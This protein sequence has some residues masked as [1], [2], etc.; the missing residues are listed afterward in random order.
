MTSSTSSPITDLL[1]AIQ[2][3]FDGHTWTKSYSKHGGFE[4]KVNIFAGTIIY[5]PEIRL[6][7]RTTSNLSL[8]ENLVVLECVN[9]LLEKGYKPDSLILEN[10][11]TLGRSNKGG[12]ADITVEGPDSRI[13]LIIECKTWGKE[14]EKEKTNMQLRG[15]QLFSYLRQDRNCQYLCLYASK[16]ESGVIFYENSIVKAKD[17]ETL[18]DQYNKGDTDIKLFSNAKNESELYQAWKESYACYF[19][20]NGIFDDDAAAYNIDLKPLKIKDLKHLNSGDS[21][22]IYN[23]FAEIL[24]HN[25]IS[26]RENAF[27]K[28]ISL[29]LCKMVDENKDMEDVA[30]FQWVEGRDSYEDLQDRL[31]S[32]YRTGMRDY[33]KEEVVYFEN[34]FVDLAFRHNAKSVAKDKMLQMLKELKF[35][36]NNEF[37]FKEVHNKRLF[38]QNAKVLNE[39]VQLL[40][41]YRFKYSSAEPFLG[42]LFE[43][44]LN[45]GVKQSEGQFFTP[46]PIAQFIMNCL[47]LPEIVES[48]SREIS[49]FPKLIDYACGSG[50][51]L[52]QAIE[53]IQNII[54][55]NES[56]DSV[57][58]SWT[59]DSI[60]GV[61]RD[62]R[63]ARIAKIACFM[64]GAG[65]ANIIYGDGLDSH[66]E[67]GK[68]ES[69]DILV[70]NP[71]YSIK[72]F[73]QHLNLKNNQ[74][75]NLAYLTENSSEIEVLFIER[76]GQ[77]IKPGG[78]AA[79]ILPSSI[80]SNS[81]AYVNARKYI[82]RNFDIKGIVELGSGTFIATGTTT[83]VLFLRKYIESDYKHFLYRANEIFDSAKFSDPEY[84]DEHLLKSYCES[85]D[86]SY[87]DYTTIVKNY[88][89]GNNDFP[90]SFMETELY[91]LYVEKFKNT[92]LYKTLS[93]D[94]GK[95]N[96]ISEAAEAEI[97]LKIMQHYIETE[98]EKFIYYCISS[99]KEL[100][101]SK[102][103]EKDKEAE[104]NFL[105]YEWTKRR[106]FEGMVSKGE[107]KLYDPTNRDNPERISTYIRASYLDSIPEEIHPSLSDYVRIQSLSSMI[108]FTQNEIDLRISID[109]MAQMR[110]SDKFPLIR[111]DKLACLEYGK[112]LPK[113]NRTAGANT[114]MGSNGPHG[115]HSD[116]LVDGPGVVIGRKGS[117]GKVSYCTN[118][119]WPI[120]TTYWLRLKNNDMSIEFAYWLLKWLEP[121]RLV[122]NKSIGVPGLNRKDVHK[123]MIPHVPKDIQEK[124][125][126]EVDGISDDLKDSE[127]MKIGILDKYLSPSS[128]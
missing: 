126:Q 67:L 87:D 109:E 52:T 68:D 56:N 91:G 71:P 32:L 29:F 43:L 119:F 123:A 82:L 11:W 6:G 54:R 93:K 35:Y 47:P 113:K 106:G 17:D 59:R 57:S 65:D 74:F 118:N 77:L 13:L 63:L 27:N 99:N 48:K 26:D 121:S 44:L 117:A 114:V 15:G 64:N 12:K 95:A 105:G 5:G 75:E 81:G 23:Q 70:A 2:F 9:R 101:V 115:T 7:D 84:Q 69:F 78:H 111:F 92:T 128:E 53:S 34:N 41:P 103:P 50:H 112:A 45:A 104:K 18:I 58:T 60:Y 124:I 108:D 76:I 28:M 79:V 16:V 100:I 66:K 1:T 3:T 20:P 36:T 90:E 14:Y 110:H 8:P 24:R 25:N 97:K 86:I 10:K 122:G 116:K 89:S 127:N 46:I 4:I 19:H 102:S 107:G 72:D 31:Q 80:L 42:N 51:F 125:L 85:I 37:A 30:D 21:G 88:S 73:K 98:K 49:K 33:L 39:V 61:E 94:L 62:Y 83:V 22:F 96:L 38:E 40:Q 120:D 55:E